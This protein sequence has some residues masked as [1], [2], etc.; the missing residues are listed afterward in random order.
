MGTIRGK[1]WS[2]RFLISPDEF[3]DWI[4]SWNDDD[5]NFS[6]ET[7]SLNINERFAQF[8]CARMNP[9]QEIKPIPSV[10]YTIS[11][12]NFHTEL[13]VI[14]QETVFFPDDKYTLST[15][16]IELSAPAQYAVSCE[17]GLHFYYEDILKKEPAAYEVFAKFRDQIKRITKPLYYRGKPIYSIRISKQAYSDLLKSAFIMGTGEGLSATW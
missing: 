11:K 4:D 9:Q 14:N 3:R 16:F 12:T 6:G 5:F 17:D 15:I 13:N 8:Y 10:Y 2:I 7:L 1:W